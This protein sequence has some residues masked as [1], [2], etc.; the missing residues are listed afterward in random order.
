MV[1]KSGGWL[2][3]NFGFLDCLTPAV[4]GGPIISGTTLISSFP[5]VSH[6]RCHSVTLCTVLKASCSLVTAPV[7]PTGVG[8]VLGYRYREVNCFFR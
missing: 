3:Q 4:L 5:L 7:C 8:A 1:A 6:I 2:R